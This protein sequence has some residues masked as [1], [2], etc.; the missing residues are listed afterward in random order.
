M[1]Y[2]VKL[3]CA[4]CGKM[5]KQPIRFIKRVI[6]VNSDMG[7]YRIIDDGG[8]TVTCYCP[9]EYCACIKDGKALLKRGNHMGRVN[10]VFIIKPDAIN[11]LLARLV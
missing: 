1:K 10:S 6:P 2:I 9:E 7:R 4:R 5:K 11:M 8:W 3:I